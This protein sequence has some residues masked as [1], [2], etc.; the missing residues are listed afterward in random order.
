M[1]YI[2]NTNISSNTSTS[3]SW[4]KIHFKSCQESYK[5]ISVGVNTNILTLKNTNVNGIFVNI[6]SLGFSVEQ[7]NKNVRFYIYRNAV[8]LGTPSFKTIETGSVVT[9]DVNGTIFSSGKKVL[10]FSSDSNSNGSGG[11]VNLK[12]EN[13][14]LYNGETLTVTAISSSSA[15]INI[16]LHWDEVLNA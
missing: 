7:G 5:S 15:T 4:D 12:D 2:Q 8:I 13:I 6:N 1:S 10:T 14:R 11:L 16:S 9:S 3:Y